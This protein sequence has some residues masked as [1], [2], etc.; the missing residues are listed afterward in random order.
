MT[1]L[2]IGQALVLPVGG[3][4]KFAFSLR[5]GH[6]GRGERERERMEDRRWK[7]EDR[8]QRTENIEERR[9]GQVY[10]TRQRRYTI[11]VFYS[12]GYEGYARG[13]FYLGMQTCR[14]EAPILPLSS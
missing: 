11:V 13:I 9:R 3:S 4:G 7:I 2:K 10:A 5:K 14:E 8:E 1:R 6:R 12:R